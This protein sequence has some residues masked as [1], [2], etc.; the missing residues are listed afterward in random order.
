MLGAGS[1]GTRQSSFKQE[2]DRGE[3]TEL[4]FEFS[5]QALGPPLAWPVTVVE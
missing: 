4:A 2:G 5:G 3:H 1:R